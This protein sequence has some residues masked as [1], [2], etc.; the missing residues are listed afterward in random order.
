MCDRM[1]SW[2]VAKH[3][4]IIK[5]L[6]QEKRI[7][8]GGPLTVLTW[9]VQALFSRVGCEAGQGPELCLYLRKH[10]PGG[11]N[12]LHKSPKAGHAWDI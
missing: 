5:I 8:G 3:S 7:W 1:V 10:I 12:S 6:E 4:K 2:Y 11:A 9:V